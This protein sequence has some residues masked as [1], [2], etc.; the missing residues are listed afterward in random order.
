VFINYRREDTGWAANALA[1]ALRR[2]LG[3]NQVFLDNSSILLGQQFE[4]ALEDGVRR[5]GVLV[6]L[7]GPGWDR[8]PLLDRLQ[9]PGDW[10]R[11]ELILAE[12]HGVLTIPVLVDRQDLPTQAGLPAELGFLPGRATRLAPPIPPRGSRLARHQH[13]PATTGWP[14]PNSGI[15]R[16]GSRTHPQRR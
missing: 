2:R 1:D 5:S 12:Q 15:R 9:D 3:P 8:P 4:R 7:I 13:R 10:V 16:G 6:A 14:G 11:R